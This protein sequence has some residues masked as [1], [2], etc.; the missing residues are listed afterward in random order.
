MIEIDK[1][2]IFRLGDCEVIPNENSL[3][4][5]EPLPQGVSHAKVSIQPKF[6]ELL[7]LLARKYPN[8][9]T[10]DELIDCIW[11]GNRYVGAKALTN[12]VWHLRKQLNPLLG[13]EQAIETVRKTGYRLLIEPEFDA[14]DLVDKPDLLRAEQAKVKR[15]SR[16]LRSGVCVAIT[17]LL[18]LC[19]GAGFHLYQDSQRLLQTEL[20]QLTRSAGA[21]L[22]PAVSPDGRWLVYGK[23]SNLYLKDLASPAQT[24]KRLTS[25]RTREL[26]AVWAPDGKSLI[27]PSEDSQ[28]RECSMNRLILESHE[29]SRLA[30][31]YSYTSALDIS[32]DGGTLVYIWRE[33]EELDSGLYLLELEEADSAPVRFSCESNCG[34]RDRDVAFS[35]DGKWIAIARRYGTISEDIFIQ[36][37]LSGEEVRLTQGLEDIRGLSW[38]P[39]SQTLVFSTEN[40]GIRD[41]FVV[42]IESKEL[43]P[44]S[45]SGF[46]YPKFIPHRDELVYSN[47]IKDF[48][49]AYLAL[50][51]DIPST[52]FPISQA[53]YSY[54]N[55]D[56]SSVT[57]RIAYVSNETGF[58]E[59]WTS[60]HNGFNRVQLT[61]LKRRVAYPSWSHDG[62]KIAFLAPDDKNEGN[63]IH[64]LDLSSGGISILPSRFLD[65]RRPG[66]AWG[67]E[68]VLSSTHEGLTAFSLHNEAPKHLSSIDVRL[69][70]MTDANTILFT[71][72]D[73]YGLWRMDISQPQRVEPVIAAEDFRE[74][75]NW[76]VTDKGVY[77]REV[78]TGYQLINYRSFTTDLTTPI[79]KLP[80]SSL[81]SFGAMSYIPGERRLL[82]TLS[83]YSKRDVI[84]LK[85]KLL[86]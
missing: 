68:W 69:S 76:T 36:D 74:S 75:Y 81:S 47:Y 54:R 24:P 77:F 45:I 56:Y 71:R 14:S 13:G 29:V 40:S 63:K 46:S 86:H 72:Y 73:E 2:A 53:E 37:I 21:E 42:D 11:E 39:D 38:G 26:R 16:Q 82:M 79:L 83:E 31:C 6:I 62:S 60:D 50:D 48:S 78:H 12:A 32:T 67:D 43:L 27:Y 41:G 35:P 52:V 61:D 58:N 4:F 57:K 59:V 34:Y 44:L 17:L 51:Q 66:W 7:S 22:Y 25:K 30:E 15:L 85:H 8:V 70:K 55:P 19:G 64:I 65:H 23:R 28:T 18:I 10:R 80:S 3:N 1:E 5:S 9:V 20:I 33:R 84:K 49:L